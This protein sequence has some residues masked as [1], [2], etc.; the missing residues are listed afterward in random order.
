MSRFFNK[1]RT[2][3]PFKFLSSFIRIEDM[4]M[5]AL[6]AGNKWYVSRN[7]T[8]SGDG[9][10]WDTAFKTIGEAVARVNADYI[11]ASQPNK[12]RNTVIFVGEGSY[13][14][15]PLT[16][17]ANDCR[18]IGMAAG[19]H[20]SIILYGSATADGFDI[21]AGAP[22]LTIEGNNC[23]VANMGFFTHDDSEPGLRI[24]NNA[25]GGGAVD[26][27]GTHI[28][29]CNFVRNIADGE[30]YGIQSFGADAT[31]IEGC[32]FGT[33]CKNA[34]IWVGTNGVINPVNTFIKNCIFVGCPIALLNEASAHVTIFEGNIV[35]DDTSDRPDSVD[36]PISNTGGVNLIAINNFWEFSEANAITGAG[37]HLMVNN[38]QL[39]AT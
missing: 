22:A 25:A 36:V 23:T 30:K 31:W 33:S 16:L 9:R 4:I 24:G 18:I 35:V 7:K 13:G 37:D 27:V 29:N 11:A 28:L 1:L 17:T 26:T 39:A 14:E 10:S 15:V 8:T 20:D 3:M 12:G 5:G 32:F 34:G 6:P 21:G 2:P 38:F 19:S